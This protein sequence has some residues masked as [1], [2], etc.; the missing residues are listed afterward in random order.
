MAINVTAM[1]LR[2]HDEHDS[3]FSAEEANGN[4]LGSNNVKLMS[5]VEQSKQINDVRTRA[6]IISASGMATGGRVMHHLA[7]RLPDSRNCVLLCGFQAEG[8][9]GRALEEGAKYLRI[10]GEVVPVRA[11]IVN[12]RQ[13]SAHAGRSELM[14]WLA[15]LPS[16]P[17]Q[18]Y[19]VHGEPTASV[20]LQSAIERSFGWNTVLPHH[21][22]VVTLPL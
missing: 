12:L 19:L 9:G 5:T 6:I 17:K 22:Q 18:L 21:G 7:R 2:H 8:T 3:E 11:E 16:P 15:G 14:R 4:P 10:H 1:Y 20:A 13:F